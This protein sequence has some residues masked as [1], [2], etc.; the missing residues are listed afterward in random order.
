MGVKGSGVITSDN[1]PFNYRDAKVSSQPRRCRHR[2]FMGSFTPSDRKRLICFTFHRFRL[3]Q[4]DACGHDYLNFP[5]TDDY[6]SGIKYCGSGDWNLGGDYSSLSNVFSDDLC[7]KF[8]STSY[9]ALFLLFKAK[10][11]SFFLTIFLFI[12]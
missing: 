4:S 6:G 10:S 8:V 11:G 2:I 12:S 3:E 1:Y 9:L 7:C 5:G